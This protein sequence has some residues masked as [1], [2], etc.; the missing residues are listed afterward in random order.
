MIRRVDGWPWLALAAGGGALLLLLVAVL[1]L[2]DRARPALPTLAVEGVAPG[3]AT[4]AP[5]F[6][7]LDGLVPFAGGANP[8]ADVVVPEEHAPEFRGADW[9]AQQKPEAWTIQVMAARDE[10]AVMR[11][12]AEREDRVDFS[13]FQYPHD[14][15]Q[16]FVVTLGSFPTRELAD[17]VAATKGLPRGEGSA[18]PRRFAVYQEALRQPLPGGDPA[19]APAPPAPAA[20]SLPAAPPPGAA[21]P[22]PAPAAPPTPA[23]P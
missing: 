1:A 13:Y 19:A 10:Q 22:P 18:F 17:G 2:Q 8:V 21:V 15:A 4:F 12:L 5:G 14:G 7:R 20:P 23:Q 3:A 6:G 9:V 16:W 11:F